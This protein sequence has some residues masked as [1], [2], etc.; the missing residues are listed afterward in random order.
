MNAPGPTF[1]TI[2]Q[3]FRLHHM[4]I[5]AHGGIAGIRDHGGLE[6]ALAAAENMGFYRDGDLFDIAA[7]YAFHLA[8]SQA[9]LD[10][11]KRTAIASAL[12]FLELNSAYSPPNQD[13]LYDAMIAL[14]A[15]KMDKAELADVLRRQFP[16]P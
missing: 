14:S 3:V 1:L 10:G 2:Q 7:A 4:A 8:E 11:N 12:T 5:E 15:H 6:S 9:F 13:E 16:R